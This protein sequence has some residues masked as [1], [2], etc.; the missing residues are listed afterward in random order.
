MKFVYFI[1]VIVGLCVILWINMYKIHPDSVDRPRGGGGSRPRFEQS[2]TLTETKGRVL[3]GLRG[4]TGEEESKFEK[5][6]LFGLTVYELLI[7]I[8]FLIFM[9]IFFKY[10]SYNKIKTKIGKTITN[11]YKI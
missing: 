3:K 6:I 9:L 1:F 2:V 8:I 4:A 5:S 11:V 7:Y 10:V